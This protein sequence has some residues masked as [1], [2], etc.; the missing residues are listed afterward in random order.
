MDDYKRKVRELQVERTI[1][2]LKKNNMEA[3]FLPTMEDVLPKVT[4]LLKPGEKVAVG[5]S[6]SL[7]ETGVL[8]ALR[9]GTYEF[10]DRYKKGLTA[11][12]VQQVFR[13]SFSADSFLA[14]ANAVTEHGELYCTDGNSNRVAAMLFG[15]KQVILVVSWDKLVPD[16]GAAVERVK[17]VAAPANAIRLN[18]DTYCTKNGRCLNPSCSVDNLMALGAGAC[19]H[20]ICANYVVFSHQRVAKRI[21]VLIVG[22]SFGY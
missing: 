15:P 18:A 7:E 5:G 2:A 16:L 9:S 3:E 10:L 4:S 1:K 8:Q 22:E 11:E 14:S 20:T 21:K 17:Q 12:E 13:D 6:A 19:E